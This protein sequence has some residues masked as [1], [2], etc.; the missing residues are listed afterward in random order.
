[1]A[2]SDHEY[3][4][5]FQCVIM[6]QADL[7]CVMTPQVRAKAAA[8]PPMPQGLWEAG[9]SGAGDLGSQD[10]LGTQA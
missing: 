5:T 1:M 9:H 10:G 2:G 4:K 3:I 8:L 6:I 7:P